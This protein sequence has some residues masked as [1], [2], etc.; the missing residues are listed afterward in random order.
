M[1]KEACSNN[2]YS[3]RESSSERNHDACSY[4]E[5]LKYGE[6]RLSKAGI[7]EAANDAW[8][9]FSE[10][11]Q[12]SRARY[13]M[14]MNRVCD[15]EKWLRYNQWLKLRAKRI[16]L[17]HI[18]GHASFMG[19]EFYVNEHVLTPRADTEILVEETFAVIKRKAGEK[20]GELV[21]ILDMCTGSG[22]IAISL[23]CMAEEMGISCE[24]TAVDLSEHA[25]L[26]AGRNNQALCHG[27]VSLIKSNLFESLPDTMEFDI[28]VSNPP[29]IKSE[30][31]ADLMPEVRDHEPRMALDGKE[32]GLYFYRRLAE[33]GKNFLKSGGR[34]LFEIGYD[35]SDSIRALAKAGNMS[36]KVFR[37][38]GGN[39]RVALLRMLDYN[40]KEG[41]LW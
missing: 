36:C 26:V 5:C 21:R 9:L 22:C 37:D 4:R 18:T 35:Q 32:D 14:D 34:I 25:L 38:Y 30:E 41:V 7:S 23:A 10:V 13:Y 3:N 1:T 8:L 11:F 39:D 16:P 20:R 17:Q 6:S 40:K 28:I 15:L 2:E 33:E 27:K 19:Y 31:I 24:I 29:Y 12:V